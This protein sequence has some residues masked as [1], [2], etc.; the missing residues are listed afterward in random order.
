M[1][2]SMTEGM[3]VTRWRAVCTLMVLATTL[4]LGGFV[5]AATVALAGIKSR[6]LPVLQ[7]FAQ[8]AK[9]TVVNASPDGPWSGA[10]VVIWQANAAR[11]KI[12]PERAKALGRF[13]RTGGGLLLTMSRRPGSSVMALAF[14]LPTTGWT[15][16]DNRPEGPTTATRWA[17]AF[18]GTVVPPMLNVDYHFGIHRVAARERGQSRYDIFA[19]KIPY[20]NL[21]LKPGQHFWTRPLLDC[22]W[23][24]LVRSDR[25]DRVPLM[26]AGRYG[27]GHVIVFAS[28]ARALE[29][30][31][32]DPDTAVSLMRWLTASVSRADL[33]AAPPRLHPQLITDRQEHGFTVILHNPDRLPLPVKLV[34]R[35]LSWEHAYVTTMTQNITVPADGDARA[36]FHLPR[37]GP[38]SF[39]E[40]VWHDAYDVR[41]GV[42]SAD[43]SQML[44]ESSGHINLEPRAVLRLTCD[45]VL[46]GQYP[47]HAPGPK[48]MTRYFAARLGLPTMRYAYQPGEIIHLAVTLANGWSNLAPLAKVSDKTDPGNGSVVALTDG[49]AEGESRPT[50]GIKAWGVWQ[51]QAGVENDLDFNFSR[52][53]TVAG[54]QLTGA[55]WNHR[56]YLTHNP[57]AMVLQVDG[58]TVARSYDLDTR[59]V[60]GFGR[61]TLTFA[62]QVATHIR[63]RLPWVARLV[64]GRQ[65]S[66]P[67]LGEV[68]ILGYRGSKPKAVAGPLNV[69]LINALTGKAVI[70]EKGFLSARP[71]SRCQNQISLIAPHAAVLPA[72][73]RLTARWNGQTRTIPIMVTNGRDALHPLKDVLPP[74][75]IG[76][77]FI[78][79]RGFRNAF[80]VGTGTQQQ[81]GGWGNPDDLVWAYSHLMKQISSFAR[82]DAGRLFVNNTGFRHYCSPWQCFPNGQPFFDLAAP[83]FVK[84][85]ETRWDWPRSHTVVFGF[86]DRWDTGPPVD[87]LNSW[88]N[89]V[90]FDQYLR[91]H[92]LGKLH[93]G[94]HAQ[95]AAQVHGRYR[96]E[97]NWYQLQCYLRAMKV[98]H[99]TFAH[100]GKKLVIS[101]QGVP[102]VAGPR[103]K[104]LAQTIKAMSDDCSWGAQYNDLPYTTGRN[105][106]EMA[107]NPVWQMSTLFQWG[108]NSTTLN[109][110]QWRVPVGTTE[111]S[112]RT[113]FDRAFRGTINDAGRYCS[114]YTYGYNE[115]GGIAYTMNADD[116]QQLWRV[117]VL[118]SLLRPTDPIG[119]G[120]IVAN[121]EMAT[122]RHCSFTGTETGW[123]NADRLVATVAHTVR[124]LQEAGLS[125]PF[126]AN[127]S[128]LAHWKGTAPLILLNPG[129]FSAA[130]IQ[131][132][133]ALALRGVRIAAFVGNLPGKPPAFLT[134]CSATVLRADPSSLTARQAEA[135]APVL[136]D[137]LDLRLRFPTGVLGYGFRCGRRECLVIE[138]WLNFGRTVVV[139]LR[140]EPHARSAAAC[141]LTNGRSLSIQRN[142]NDWNIRIPLRPGGAAVVCLQENN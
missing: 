105:M 42:L 65:R 117:Q 63:L 53:V 19:R 133:E 35:I 66:T 62:P 139:R 30:C 3:S 124:R 22:D 38:K 79:T 92:D 47:F 58:K 109:N 86:S 15:A 95:V 72:F 142:H 46:A 27:A 125:V 11:L 26:L 113:A 21:K 129:Q 37:P 111:P 88:Q 112:R 80:S 103:A 123:N 60:R 115:N 121:S 76:M 39:Q 126:A 50:Q 75:A 114:L 108:W 96:H 77:G 94:T 48:N 20:L 5:D 14:M 12:T 135:L 51:G 54:V 128:T 57:G 32:H 120:L 104:I 43:G 24:V 140:A 69:S 49:A 67:W 122:P 136:R 6:Q 71:A 68:R 131:S 61:V 84:H 9:W 141:E 81:P 31:W 87:L 28:S 85:L 59:F 91:Q 138:N 23:R 64:R 40:L 134:T 83:L 90:A 106:G 82:T 127:A 101:A 41:L 29:P 36:I 52:P 45:N 8:R 1:G 78:V 73:Y 2:S 107:F 25:F 18:W 17:P 119:A 110:P 98:L 44:G 34:G 137:S 10:R 7:S 99:D 97:W 118:Q 93:R 74:G 89:Y 4:S 56:F 100:A 102:L 70:L 55:A 132:V 116:W 16:V 33:P 13:V 130:E